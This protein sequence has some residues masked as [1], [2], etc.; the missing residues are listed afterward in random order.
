MAQQPDEDDP[1][2][3]NYRAMRTVRAP[4][5][6]AAPT[7]PADPGLRSPYE[8]E[9]PFEANLR[10]M[11][12]MRAPPAGG[13]VKQPEE[14]APGATWFDRAMTKGVVQGAA[15]LPALAAD[16]AYNIVTG[17]GA[18]VYKALGKE[19][20]LQPGMPASRKV[21]EF[22]DAAAD[23]AGFPRPTTDKERLYSAA[24]EG[25]AGAIGGRIGGGVVQ[26]AG[27]LAGQAAPAVGRFL[28]WIGGMQSAAPVAQAVGGAAGGATTEYLTQKGYDPVTASVGG[29]AAGAGAS[30][31]VPAARTVRE[32]VRPFTRGGQEHLV[33]RT[34][35]EFA[36]DPAAARARAAN[37]T[38]Y[39]PGSEP[40][41][42][43][44]TG[45][46]GLLN[47]ERG[48]QRLPQGAVPLGERAIEQNAARLGA[49][50][51]LA[52]T[53]A[54]LEAARTARTQAGNAATGQLFDQAG[55]FPP[56]S[57]RSNIPLP[58][59]VPAQ[60]RVMANILGEVERIKQGRAGTS[61]A[62]RV[63][64]SEVERQLANARDPGTLYA[65]RDNIQT[66]LQPPKFGMGQAYTPQNMPVDLSKTRKFIAPVIERIDEA[67]EEMA[68]GYRA[69]MQA[70]RASAQPISQ[71]EVLQEI[72]NRAVSSGSTMPNT[73]QPALN[74]SSLNRAI[75]AKMDEVNQILTP[76]QRQNL[77]A[78]VADLNRSEWVNNRAVR[79]PGSDTL[80]NISVANVLG[81]VLGNPESALS[82]TI[83]GRP[84]SF[85]LRVP[86]QQVT[87]L[88]VEAV[89]DPRLASLLMSR[90]TTNNIMGASS[91][92]ARL[93]A[94]VR[95]SAVQAAQGPEERVN[96]LR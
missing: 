53:E 41:L 67:L 42:G 17:P 51:N 89:R 66:M 57:A 13:A 43:Q 45:D 50:D 39:V 3:R 56:G 18:L 38:Q 94:G 8:P 87:E 2:E 83:L 96:A 40:T 60:P 71:M 88:L 29:L 95:G 65:A 58:S 19:P 25:G 23:R 80:Q 27:S 77:A 49:L 91:E 84:L 82:R 33:G 36:A 11:K 14:I 76:D 63:A 24:V 37:P 32:L 48:A 12:S 93:L 20:P 31:V 52:G 79:P 47:L 26:A 5:P 78:I 9:D 46:V 7:G 21:G 1:F 55:P 28:S 44:A 15:G 85:L 61:D 30:A 86:E 62:V 72:R 10:A 16:A 75:G 73:T 6:A 54:Q 22:A 59:N 92:L 74:L 64:V 68:P 69:Y 4:A 34:L 70:Q 90:A 81:R 35:N